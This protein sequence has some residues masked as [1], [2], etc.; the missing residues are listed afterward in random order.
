MKL[1]T[2]DT[3]I[4]GSG[5]AGLNAAIKAAKT[6]KVLI[7]TKKNLEDSNTFY[8]QGGI[9]TVLKELNQKDTFKKHIQDTFV[10]G[11]F[12]NDKKAVEFII[13]EGPKAIKR[14]INLGVKFTKNIDGDLALHR[15]G[16]HQEKR[17]IH[18]G[19]YTGKAIEEA[20]IKH[21]KKNKNIF[22]LENSFVKDLIIKNRICYGVEVII[23]KRITCFYAKKTVLAT[24]G[25][26][27]LYKKTTNPL[28]ATGDGLAMAI[29]AKCK[30]KDL[31]FIQFHPTAL[32]E[33]RNPLFL[34]S[35]ALRGHGATL[36]NAK[37]E[38]FMKNYHPMQ[39][40]APRDIVSR[41]IFSESQKGP[42]YL[43]LKTKGSNKEFPQISNYLKKIGYNLEKD[44]I[45]ITPAAHFSC[46]GIFTNL[47]GETSIKNLY[48]FGEV[49]CTGLHGANRLASNSLLEAVVMSNEII[50][51][52][53]KKNK[54]FPD[55]NKQIIK[56]NSN[57][58]NK[59]LYHKIKQELQDT[60]WKNVAIIKEKSKL[61]KSRIK[62]NKLLKK[63]PKNLNQ[64]GYET[65]NMLEVSLK[66]IE[67]A[68]KRKKSLGTHF[69]IN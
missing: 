66:I 5:L 12:H 32:N 30:L 63:L 45:P 56:I 61:E 36:L 6:G 14:L 28:V 43:E 11:A 34:L 40:L 49:A 51:T 24:G 58:A 10:A 35:E 31:E 44:L 8:A 4:V 1:K 37:R 69:R 17:I 65:L 23:K 50:K 19:D 60:M 64:E 59:K 9:A 47:K 3:I 7:V 62:I 54:Q 27:Q 57:V 53:P 52:K 67:A 25:I 48:A 26:G 46:G 39:E 22:I 41:A 38:R 20:L 2:F 16:G 68:L 13:K 15:E 29:R 21:I 18:S 42:I 55:F 33:G